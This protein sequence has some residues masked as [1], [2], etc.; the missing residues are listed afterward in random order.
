VE[1]RQ[2]EHFVA[3][4]EEQNFTR[5]ASRCNLS[6][7]ALSASIRALERELGAQLLVRTTRS[8]ELSDAGEA[9]L[10]KA[11]V[12]L[13]VVEAAHDAVSATRDQLG[14]SVGVGGIPTAGLLDQA[15]LLAQFHALHPQVEIR[16]ET[17]TSVDLI[18]KVRVGDLDLAF[19]TVPGKPRNGVEIRELA[20]RPVT[21]VCRADHSLAGQPIVEP[22]MLADET[23][24][25][26]PARTSAVAAVARMYRLAGA[27]RRLT[28]HVNDVA[29]MLDFVANGLGVALLPSY[30]AE[31]RAHLA[32]VP[33]SDPEM[34]WT[35]GVVSA[36]AEM[37]SRATLALLELLD[38]QQIA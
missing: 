4:V 21:L 28:F 3:V 13:R 8:V 2:I 33:L 15:N 37:R 16:Y 27:K 10:E 25:G 38:A 11:R 6:Q 20:R 30:L 23:F 29:S 31:T 22:E 18:D 7:S 12:L 32:S 19:V 17:G 9:L 14:G 34:M 35:L 1:L 26:G 24:V 36:P 5:A